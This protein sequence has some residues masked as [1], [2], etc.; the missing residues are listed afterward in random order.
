MT[1]NKMS[2]LEKLNVI[3]NYLMNSSNTAYNSNNLLGDKSGVALFLFY[4][5]KLTGR[6][7]CNNKAYDL[8]EDVIQIQEAYEIIPASVSKY[9]WLLNHLNKHGFIEAEVADYFEEINLSLL[10]F[11]QSSLQKD[12]YDFLH[13]SLGIANYFLSVENQTNK[14]I[15]VEFVG[16]FYKSALQNENGG[17]KWISILD[18]DSKKKGFNISMSHGISSIISVF[19]KICSKGIET[20][21]TK[22]IIEGAVS[23]LL[24]QKLP[25][26]QYNSIYPNFA[27]ESMD[28]LHSSRLAWC[29]GDLG[30]S[31]A[32]WHAS[33]ALGRKDWE[34]E[35]I[36]TILHASKR[37]GLV[38]NGVVDAGLCHGTAGIAHIFNRMYGYTG[39]EELKE[40]S[41][42]WFA[43]TLKMARFEDGLAGFKAWQGNE[44]G[45]VNEP[46]LLEGIAGIGL[47]LISAVSDIEPAWDE[48][49][50]LS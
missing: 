18:F 10:E 42:Y 4:M 12:N 39:L 24:N 41:N 40:A 14:H 49:L 35:A 34:Q 23:Y 16:K 9:G 22:R 5:Y 50:L 48:C 45:W 19:S 6:D 2:I 1:R 13:G 21:I 31:V 7:E 36:D 38:E 20:K 32:L 46:G 27:I 29:Y 47:A 44:R 33:Q 17:L 8:L 3:A 15:V 43:E 26:D 11:M 25:P 28:K 30:I 37:R